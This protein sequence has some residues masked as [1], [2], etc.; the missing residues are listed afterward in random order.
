M[1]L[2]VKEDPAEGWVEI[3][4][5]KYSIPKLRAKY[6]REVCWACACTTLGKSFEAVC[7]HAGKP[8]HEPGGALHKFTEAERREVSTNLSQYRYQPSTSAGKP[9]ASSKGSGNA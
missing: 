4:H 7:P 9:G 5:T 1:E 8:G 3:A 2:G 6:G